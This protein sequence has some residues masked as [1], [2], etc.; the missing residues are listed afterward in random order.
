MPGQYRSRR[1]APLPGDS[2]LARQDGAVPDRGVIRDPDLARQRD[3]PA[4]PRGA[5]DAGLPAE[6][7]M[8]ADDDVVPIWTRLSIFVPSPMTVSP[9]V[10][11][12]I[13]ALAPISTSSPTRTIPT[14]GTF[15]CALPS[16]T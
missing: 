5:P 6:D 14:W 13:V 10:A 2:G 1:D 9:R 16:Q 4:D 12:S 15:R 3:A 11:R 8:L 7:R